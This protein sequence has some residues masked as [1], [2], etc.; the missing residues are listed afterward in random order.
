[1]RSWTRPAPAHRDAVRH[2]VFARVYAKVSVATE[3]EVGPYRAELLAGLSGRVVEVGAGNGLNFGHY[4][5]SVSEV[6]AIEPEAVLRR[7]AR[8]AARRSGAPVDVVPGVAEAL[9]LKGEAFDAAVLCLVLCSVR[10]TARTLGELHRVLRPGG[11]LRF[12]EHGVAPGRA[13]AAAQRGL[14]RTVWPF[15]FGG[16]HVARDPV[17]SIERAGFVVESRRPV[18]IPAKGPRLPTSYLVL[19]TARRAPSAGA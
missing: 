18:V 11:V 14:D 2:P 3:P 19:G 17:A 1:M 16:C 9:P 12:F 10:D 15:L 7:L 5:P 8:T 6:V 13:M 4:P